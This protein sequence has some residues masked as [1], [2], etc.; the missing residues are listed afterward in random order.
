MEREAKE[1]N[2]QTLMCTVTIINFSLIVLK[3]GHNFQYGSTCVGG[4]SLKKEMTFE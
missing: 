3:L 4:L 2:S 1:V